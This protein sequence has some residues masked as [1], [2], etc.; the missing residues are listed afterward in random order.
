[1][2]PDNACTQYSLTSA[3]LTQGSPHQRTMVKR[4][5][6]RGP[7]GGWGGVHGKEVGD[8][9]GS[10]PSTALWVDHRHRRTLHPYYYIHMWTTDTTSICGPQTQTLHPHYYIHGW[11]TDT[12]TTSILL[13]SYVDHR[14][15]H[16]LHPYYH[17]HMWTTDTDT[18]SIL[19]HP[20]VD[21]LTS[22]VEDH[23]GYRRESRVSIPCLEGETNGGRDQRKKKDT[24][25]N[26]IIIL[27]FNA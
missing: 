4:T 27:C 10:L 26:G 24:G 2:R 7:G 18:T 9:G 17:I 14:H 3:A 11:T 25:T 21:A 23:P 13:Q 1:M 12:D 22:G 6:G 15:R 19:L 8:R 20:W 5:V 16:T